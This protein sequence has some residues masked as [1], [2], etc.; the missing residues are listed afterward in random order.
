MTEPLNRED[1]IGLLQKLGSEQDAEVLESAR[2]VHAQV[3]GAG[4]SWNELLVENEPDAEPTVEPTVDPTV[5]PI[6]EPAA[7]A[8]DSPGDEDEKVET[9][10]EMAEK[11][12]ASLVLIDKLLAKPDI[13]ENFR[14]EM[15][16]YKK[17]IAAGDFLETDRR[18]LRALHKRLK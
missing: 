4:L 14:G 1:V 11:N 8:H 16:D 18:Y 6:A 5:D 3:T 9:P 10:A 17:D 7:E 15:E 12:A 13:S 2:K